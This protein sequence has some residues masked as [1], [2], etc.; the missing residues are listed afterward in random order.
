M[1]SL[2]KPLLTI[3]GFRT[4][5]PISYRRLLK[6]EHQE[7]SNFNT[8]LFLMIDSYV[9]DDGEDDRRSVHRKLQKSVIVNDYL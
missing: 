9:I 8:V 5:I 4:F 7:R 3:R 6:N 2:R 1:N